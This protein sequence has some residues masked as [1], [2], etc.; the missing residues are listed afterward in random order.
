[1]PKA[2]EF[3]R[4]VFH[5]VL[6]GIRKYG[7]WQEIRSNGKVVRRN[8]TDTL[9]KLYTY[10]V[11]RDEFHHESALLY[12]NYSKLVNKAVGIASGMRDNLL[13]ETIFELEQCEN[14]CA[15]VIEEGMNSDQ[16]QREIFEACKEKLAAW[17]TLTE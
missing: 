10:S 13:A 12:T 4:W 9:A 16:S 2:R 1:M 3:Q 11:G 6:P 7:Y 8:L 5:E 15:K 14:I 17:K